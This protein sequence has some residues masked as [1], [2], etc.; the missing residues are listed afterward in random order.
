MPVERPGV[1][2]ERRLEAA[3]Q[4]RLVDVASRD[5]LANGLHTRFVGRAR[6]TGSEDE[7]AS[8][9]MPFVVGWQR[10]RQPRMDVIEPFREAPTVAVHGTAAQP[11]VAGPTVPCDHPVVERQPQRR[12]PLVVHRD[13]RQALEDVP[14]VVAEEPHEA[15]DEGRRVRPVA[16]A[17]IQPADEAS[18]DGERI[19]TGGRRLENRHRIRREVA[20]AGVPSRPRTLEQDQP[21]RSRKASAASIGRTLAT[22][23]R[24]RRRICG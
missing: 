22:R 16:E 6:Q 8:E 3:R 9:V 7:R 10:H 17:R 20:P 13:R 4:V 19:G 5:V 18:S 21:G 15:A 1:A 24:R 14:E 11:G 2:V 12:Q 23:D